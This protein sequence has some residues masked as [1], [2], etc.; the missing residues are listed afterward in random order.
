[1][2][3]SLRGGSISLGYL[4]KTYTFNR[5]PFSDIIFISPASSLSFNTMEYQDYYKILGVSR[6]A[7]ADEIK[8]SYRKL[9]RKYHPDVS[10]E[11]N[12]EEKFKQVKEA[13]EVLK[14]VEK[15]KAYDAIGSGWKQGQGFTPPPGWESRPGGEGVRPEFR[16]GFSDFFESLFGGLGQEARWT[17]QEFKQ[18]G[19]DQHSRVTVS[20]E[21]AFNGST[22]LLTLQEPIV[23]YQTGQ[24]TSKTRQLR[25]KI[26]AGVTEGQQIRLQG[27][28]LPGIGGAPNG[29]LYLEI[30]LAPH[31]LFT[32]EGK[33]VY[34]N[35]PVTPW[36]AALG[37][38]VSIPTL[39][40]SVDLTLPPGS[41]T[42]QKLRLKGRGLPGGTPGD[43]Y[44]LIKI[45]IPEPKND[46]QKELY[47][48]MAEQM[49]FDPRKE[50]LG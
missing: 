30:H 24:V 9:A 7:T 8:K 1:M 13:Y 27:Q 18:R 44:V 40:G 16:E 50:L 6:D 36:E 33:D 31:S 3:P 46:Q 10:S 41:Q 47:Q 25:I 35:L 23:D 28:G 19:Q 34:L 48:Q 29:D 5:T 15:R 2:T 32:V 49:P 26:P 14:D 11:P 17:R 43:Q 37:A 38:K 39:G 21:E 42:G 20:L 4:W 12:A 22:R 45:Y